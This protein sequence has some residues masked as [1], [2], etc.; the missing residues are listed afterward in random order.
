[1][2]TEED[3]YNPDEKHTGN[4]RGRSKISWDSQ[5]NSSMEDQENKRREYEQRHPTPDYRTKRVIPERSEQLALRETQQAPSEST[6]WTGKTC[7]G[8]KRAD[9]IKLWIDILTNSVNNSRKYHSEGDW[10]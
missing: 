2:M 8:Q 5:F 9:N 6:E 10:R 1:M 4:N 7:G 3:V